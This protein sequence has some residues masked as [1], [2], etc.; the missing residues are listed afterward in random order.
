MTI[1]YALLVLL[2]STITTLYSLMPVSHCAEFT[3]ERGRIDHSCSVRK[4]FLVILA[5]T[6]N[7]N[8]VLLVCV[9]L[10]GQYE[11]FE[12]VQKFCVPSTNNFHCCLCLSLTVPNM[13]E[14][15]KN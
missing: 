12:H 11:S 10:A 6:I 14:C 3:A 4:L 15:K 8:S 7:S 5:R 2:V 1:L 9:A 13:A